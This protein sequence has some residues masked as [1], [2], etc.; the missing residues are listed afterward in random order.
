MKEE[1]KLMLSAA[2]EAS[3]RARWVFLVAQVTSILI[4]AAVWRSSWTGW[5]LQRLRTAQAAVRVSECREKSQDKS[6]FQKCIESKKLTAEGRASGEGLL[7]QWKFDSREAR[8]YAETLEDEVVRHVI[9]VSVPFIGISLDVND[10]SLLGGLAFLL[11]IMWFRFSLWREQEN[12]CLVFQRGQSKGEQ[13]GVY[14]LLAMSQVFT[15]VPLEASPEDGDPMQGFWAGLPRQLFWTPVLV[16]GV[17]VLHDALSLD[18]GKIVNQGRAL[19]GL[20][21]GLFLLSLMVW[22]TLQCRKIALKL[23]DAWSRAARE[24]RQPKKSEPSPTGVAGG[25]L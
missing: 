20:A 10:L 17:V 13:R 2:Q 21:V 12:V 9:L 24:Y 6:D 3:Q 7:A 8:S 4:F 16:Q 5:T 19:Y 15:T 11:V 22:A 14:E 23:D 25:S 18:L 1:T